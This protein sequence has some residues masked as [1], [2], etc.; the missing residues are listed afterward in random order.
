MSRLPNTTDTTTKADGASLESELNEILIKQLNEAVSRT[1]AQMKKWAGGN[2]QFEATR[3][4]LAGQR[5][6]L[7]AVIESM[8]GDVTALE[9]L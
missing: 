8:K 5:A 9:T 4:V 2:T 1:D 3:F 6:A 7:V